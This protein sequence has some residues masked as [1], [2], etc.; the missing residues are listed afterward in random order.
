MSRGSWIVKCVGCYRVRSSRTTNHDHD[1]DHDRDP[2]L[3]PTTHDPRLRPTTHDPRPTIPPARR[4]SGL[5]EIGVP[6]YPDAGVF[7][8]RLGASAQDADG[9]GRGGQDDDHD[10]A[11]AG[12]GVL[13]VHRRQLRASRAETDP[14]IEITNLDALT[15]AGNPDN[16]AD[17]E[18][19]PRYHF[20]R[21]DIADRALV[22]RLVRRGRIR[23]DRQLRRREPR[24]PLDRRRHAVPAH[25]RRRHAVPARR[26]AGGEGRPVRPGLHR[27]GLRHAPARRPAV[28][29]D[30]SAGPQQPLCRQ[31]GRRRPPGPRGASHLRDGY[32]HHPMLEQLRPLP[33]PREADPAVHHQPPGG[34][35]G[36]GLRRR[37]A[38]PRLDPRAGSLPRHRRRAAA[39]PAGRGVQLRRPERAVQHRRD[40]APC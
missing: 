32:R 25:Q 28:P 30:D 22:M 20:V 39:W 5:V 15:Y 6:G 34:H 2:R 7:P 38:G 29:R 18:D 21:G 31:Q 11:D 9:R 26:G 16:L 1:R 27:R 23:R 8:C 17:L 10:Q 12:D 24:R 19:D 14:E 37:A 13:W 3:A 4:S 36:A 40:P 33:V 35:P